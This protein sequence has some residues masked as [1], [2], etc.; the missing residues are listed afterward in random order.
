MNRTLEPRVSRRSAGSYI[1]RVAAFA[2]LLASIPLGTLYGQE[3]RIYVGEDKGISWPKL[4]KR[5]QAQYDDSAR[6]AKIEG[7]VKL[8][9]VISKDG[10]VRDIIIKEGLDTRLDAKA[11]AAVKQWE[12]EPARLNGKP[13]SF[14]VELQVNFRLGEQPKGKQK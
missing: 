13:V 8:L 6:A 7:M 11:I 2:I 4:V 9:A 14:R 3:E 12:F 5:V 10:K 1:G